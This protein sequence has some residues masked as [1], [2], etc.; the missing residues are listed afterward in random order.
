M[1]GL[2]PAELWIVF[3]GAAG[4]VLAYFFGTRT[5]KKS[6]QNRQ[7]KRDLASAKDAKDRKREIKDAS[8]QELHDRLTR[9]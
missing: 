3:A 8:D 2:I 5:G 4:T 1:L 6:E 9:K 7:M